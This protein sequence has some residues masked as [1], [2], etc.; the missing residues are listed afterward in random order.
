MNRFNENTELLQIL[1]DLV[2]KN[3]QLRFSQILNDYGFV[4]HNGI[5]LSDVGWE[6]EYYVEPA[7]ILKRV[8]KTIETL[9]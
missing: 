4:I 3:P 8:K 6:D 5:G 9:K 7:E 1:F 2:L